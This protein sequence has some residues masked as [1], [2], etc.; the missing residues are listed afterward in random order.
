M[1]HELAPN[2]RV[3][4]NMEDDGIAQV[5]MI[6]A[7][8]MNALD[9]AMFNALLEAGAALHDMPGLRA[10]VLSGEGRA[11]CAGLDLSSMGDPD[12]RRETPLTE[13]THGSAN[14]PQQA[15]LQWRKLPVPVIA[16]VH[17]VCFGGGLQIA[18]G[19]DIRVVAP[20][21]RMAVMEMKWGLIPDMAGYVL[22]KGAVRD[23]VLRELTYTNRE[24]T[25][26]QALEYGFATI[27]DAN[28]HARATAIAREI[29]N[30]NPH[31]QRAAK[32]I[33]NRYLE[34]GSDEILMAESIEQQALIGT[35]NQIE[36]VMSQMAKRKGEFVDP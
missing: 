28:P 17:G 22:W 24:F 19:A 20:D 13:R 31:A 9:P 25:G 34:I 18:C 33:F 29:A 35:K 4:I 16:A 1:R 21:A 5:R 11:F 27:V 6:R 3:S 36:A 26:Q 8:K 30:R 32:R 12:R 10:V 15:A 23:D 7:D 2:N 14:A